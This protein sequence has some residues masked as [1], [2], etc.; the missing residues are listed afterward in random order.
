MDV[1]HR[2]ELSIRAA[3]AKQHKYIFTV[4]NAHTTGNINGKGQIV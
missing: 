2:T 4:D 1:C 3:Q